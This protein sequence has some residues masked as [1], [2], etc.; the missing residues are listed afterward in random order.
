[1][2]PPVMTQPIVHFKKE[3]TWCDCSSRGLDAAGRP[4]GGPGSALKETLLTSIDPRYGFSPVSSI[5]SVKPQLI[6]VQTTCGLDGSHEIG[7]HSPGSMVC[8]ITTLTVVAISCKRADFFRTRSHLGTLSVMQSWHRHKIESNLC[9]EN[10][11]PEK[12]HALVL[13][14]MPTISKDI[15]KKSHPPSMLMTHVSQNC[16]ARTSEIFCLV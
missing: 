9:S 6:L 4:G 11:C 5:S 13:F 8:L 2:Q 3:G 14:P 15:K 10:W 7:G 12:I 1:M 16:K